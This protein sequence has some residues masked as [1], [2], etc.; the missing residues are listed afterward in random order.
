[1]LGP[2]HEASSSAV[3]AKKDAPDVIPASVDT[4]A[5]G[6]LLNHTQIC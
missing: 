6:K 3:A 2:N 4:V 5:M 1:M